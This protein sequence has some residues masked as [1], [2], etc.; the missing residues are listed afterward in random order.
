LETGIVVQIKQLHPQLYAPGVDC[1]AKP[2]VVA[3]LVPY[4]FIAAILIHVASP[5]S[6]SP[7]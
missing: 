2:L 1:F 5:V 3:S 4:G 7:V 6:D